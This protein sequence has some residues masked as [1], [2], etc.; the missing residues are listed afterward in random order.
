MN[1]AT[2]VPRVTMRVADISKVGFSDFVGVG[3]QGPDAFHLATISIAQLIADI[4]GPPNPLDLTAVRSVFFS[5]VGG[6]GSTLIWVD[7]WRAQYT[8]SGNLIALTGEV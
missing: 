5:V 1:L 8:A 6:F 4:P 2:A 7:D 3:T